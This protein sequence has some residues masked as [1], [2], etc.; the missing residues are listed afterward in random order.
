MNYLVYGL[1]VSG[2][3]CVEL[4][5]NRKEN[6]WVFDDDKLR[7]SELVNKGIVNSKCRV[8]KKL[9]KDTL[10][11]IEA[12][13]LS[14]TVR[15]NKLN[16]L[17]NELDIKVFGEFEFASQVCKAPIFGVTGTNGKTTTVN[18][19]HQ[20]CCFAGE[21]AH[22]VGNVGTPLSEIVDNIH[23]TDVVVAELSNFQ[24]EHSEKL[25]LKSAALT[26]IAPDHLDKYSSFEEY[27][28]AKQNIISCVTDCVF[29]NYD[30]KNIRKL[31]T[32]CQRYQFFSTQYLPS[33]QNGLFIEQNDVYSKQNG[34]KTKVLS[35]DSFI[36]KGA[37][38]LSNLMC[39][40]SLGLNTGLSAGEIE[41]S[42]GKLTLPRHRLEFVK[43]VNGVE[44]YNDSK[45]TNI[46]A[47]NS[48]LANFR[49]RQVVLLMGGSDKGEDFSKFK[50]PQ[51]VVTLITFGAMKNKIAKQ[52][53]A[54]CN[55][56]RCES[57]A[58][59]V[60]MAKKLALD[61]V[62]LSP[63][64]ASFDEFDSYAERGEYFCELVKEIS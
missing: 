12:I 4:L 21:K 17:V 13:I 1:G 53:K 40:I 27:F 34:H 46:H 37:H 59:A 15:L 26:N 56:F 47:V 5:L 3:A 11:S 52:V 24:L 44:Y 61:V 22:L 55:V 36:L 41:S 23:S 19:L 16:R 29:F 2:L 49:N 48:A 28:L 8:V 51:F 10:Q 25:K 35:L 38:N 33:E 6:V 20:L 58:D 43:K 9:N 60:W 14:P 57:L 7:L 18:F 42:L 64:C 63:G 50:L 54:A 62:L 45:A 39:A 30:D 32:K 31:A